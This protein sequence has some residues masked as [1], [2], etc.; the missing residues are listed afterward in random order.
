MTILQVICP[1]CSKRGNIEISDNVLKTILRGLLAV[2]V[3]E[4]TICPHSFITYIDKNLKIRDYFIADFQYELPEI[5][6]TERI[7]D[8]G[9]SRELDLS[10]IKL[11]LSPNLITYMIKSI[12]MKKKILLISTESF[13]NPHILEFFKLITQDNF[14]FNISFESEEV[15]KNKSNEFKDYMVFQ[16]N[17]IINNVNNSLNPKKLKVEKKIVQNFLSEADLNFSFI[18]LKNELHKAYLLAN[19]LVEIIQKINDIKKLNYSK[20]G[21]NLEKNQKTKINNDYLE[22]LLNIV[23]NYFNVKV[24]SASESLMDL[25]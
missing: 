3:P 16:D 8:I 12:L 18:M 4:G 2:N 13:M 10:L 6:E 9:I 22:F 5:T 15:F 20:L 7:K 25:L 21:K 19:S 17:E 14:K 11:N 1:D 24:P 23:R